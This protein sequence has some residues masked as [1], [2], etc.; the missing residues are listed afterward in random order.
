MAKFNPDEEDFNVWPTYSDVAFAIVLIL[1]FILLAQYVVMLKILDI[2]KIEKEQTRLSRRLEQMFPGQYGKDKAISDTTQPQLQKITFSDQV[3]FDLGSAEL[4]SEGEDILS[5]VAEILINLKKTSYEITEKSLGHFKAA[6][7]PEDL[8]TRLE[9]LKYR[10]YLEESKFKAA[11]DMTLNDQEMLK[12][13]SLIL[14][15]TLHQPSSF[16]EIQIRGHTDNIPIKTAIFPSNWELSSARATSVVRHFVDECGLQPGNGLLLSAQGYSEFDS[17]HDN[18][19]TKGRDLN[20]RIE[21]VIKY[22][23]PFN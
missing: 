19:T 18:R 10:S 16:D 5:G 8:L 2:D 6:E 23:L 14:A 20:R 7:L 15:T 9:E 1:V 12:Y 11:L 17:I 22:P 4:K 3:L 13:D 21:I